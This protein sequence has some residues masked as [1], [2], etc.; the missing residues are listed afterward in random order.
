M[1]LLTN[2]Q[3]RAWRDRVHTE[4]LAAFKALVRAERR[5]M[6]YRRYITHHHVF[7]AETSMDAKPDQPDRDHTR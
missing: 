7:N 2:D 6:L 4:Y 5:E 1:P 3:V